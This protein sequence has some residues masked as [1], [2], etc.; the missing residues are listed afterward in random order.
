MRW[1]DRGPEPE[2]VQEYARKFTPGWVQYFKDGVGRRP[3]DSCWREFRQLLG[4]R[5]GKNCWYCERRC[6]QGTDDD[7]RAPTL[8]HFQ[9]LSRFPDLAYRWSNWIFSCQS[10]NKNKGGGWPASGYVNPSAADEKE[11]PGEYFDYDANTGEI[12]AM[13]GL[14][15]E[16]R[17][18]AQFTIDDLGLN[19][20]DVRFYRY[21]WIRQ[22]I[23][24]W[25][26][27]PIEDRAEFVEFL[28]QIGHEFAGT[29]LMAVGQQHK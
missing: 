14:H 24:D 28:T 22:F 4:N 12:I 1:I 11:R 5:S 16:A 7:A 25:Q 15:S 20:L 21:H 13:P 2:G 29:T 9:P 27:L 8:D 17:E 18:R 26:T 19:R 3:E 23:N 6:Q 10:C